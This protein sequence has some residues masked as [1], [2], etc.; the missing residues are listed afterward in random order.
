TRLR[1]R[2]QALSPPSQ[3]KLESLSRARL[4]VEHARWLASGEPDELGELIAKRQAQRA[5]ALVELNALDTAIRR[6]RM[7]S[8]DDAEVDVAEAE[9]ERTLAGWHARYDHLWPKP[10]LERARKKIEEEAMSVVPF[11]VPN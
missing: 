3:A 1:V 8:D 9:Y 5:A 4:D 10:L 6:V 2:R 7:T 11:P